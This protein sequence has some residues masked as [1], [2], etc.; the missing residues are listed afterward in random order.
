MEAGKLPPELLSR[1]VLSRVGPRRDEV[2]VRAGLGEDAAALDLGGD[3]VVLSSDPITGAK[4]G[5]AGLAV[6]VACNDIGAMGAEPVGVLVTALYPSGTEGDAIARVTDEI[7]AAAA[8]LG[9]EVIG[10]H[11]EITSLVT[12]PIL[13]LTAV[14]RVPREG[15]RRS[16]TAAPGDAL[17]LTK[18]AGL[19]GTA[20][21]AT[22]FAHLLGELPRALVEE[23]RGFAG[24]LSS[25]R[26]GVVAAR[27]GASALHDVTEGGV[28]GACLE[29]AAASGCGVRVYRSRVPVHPATE[30]ICRHLGL[31]PLRLISS[32]AMLVA[33]PDPERVLEALREA[34]IAA[35]KIGEVVSGESVL[36]E[37]DGRETPLAGP[38]VDE[39]WRFLAGA[40]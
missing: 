9:V 23:G 14:G 39:L 6:D 20:I 3:L 33:A 11:T 36:V 29:L 21:L 2:V 19:E 22:D 1:L 10:G 40:P 35:A 26:D 38:V 27:N 28:L 34:G 24:A 13:V 15:L 18:S 5:A 31:D 4:E 17:I 12:A 30:R 32:G 7:E 16:A 8:R 37:P 25:V